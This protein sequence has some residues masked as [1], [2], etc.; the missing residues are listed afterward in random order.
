MT[1]VFYT[2]NPE[3]PVFPVSFI[4]RIFKNDELV[5]TVNYPICNPN[6]LPQAENKAEAFAK[7]EV[8][9]IID[10]ELMK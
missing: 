3:P 9:K 7:L 6:R 5:R 8:A 2:V 4:V 10:M 1:C